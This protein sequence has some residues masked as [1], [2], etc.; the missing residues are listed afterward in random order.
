M[1]ALS[2]NQRL[3]LR[4][5]IIMGTLTAVYYLWF[6]P[7]AWTLP[8]IGPNYSRFIHYSLV[9]VTEG[10]VFL[11]GLLGHE[12]E[13]FDL[14]NID[15]YESPIN[16][17][18]RNYCLGVDMTAMF[19]ALVLSFPGSWKHRLWFIPAGVLGIIGINTLR[20]AALCLSTIYFGHEQFFEHH[21][22]FNLVTTIFIFLMFV[23]WVK[24]YRPGQ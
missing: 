11:I 9:L 7:R 3:L 18:I 13:V 8:I 12:A 22:A 14:R 6:V 10:S 17:H 16:I 20:V 19:T 23:R 15:L 24:M 5:L 1:P 4:F 2:A 21:N